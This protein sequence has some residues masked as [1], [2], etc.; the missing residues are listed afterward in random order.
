MKALTDTQVESFVTHQL[1]VSPA[2]DS[3]QECLPSGSS[4]VEYCFAQLTRSAFR[5]T[6]IDDASANDVKRK[7]DS[8][9]GSHKPI[10]LAIPF[11][12]YKNYR[13]ASFPGP[14]WAEVF[15]MNYLAR[16]VMPLARC[17]KPGVILQYT[18]ISGVM[19]LVSN[20]PVSPPIT[21]MEQ[22]RSL[23]SIFAAH[24]PTNLRLTTVDIG[25]HYSK[26]ALIEELQH[27]YEDNLARWVDKFSP[28]EREKRIA[29]AGRNLMRVGAIDLSYLSEVEWST[30]CVDSAM[31]CEALDSL[32]LRRRFNK[33]SDNIQLVFVRG[34]NLSIHI[35]SCDTSA[36]HFWS[37]CGVLEPNDTG[38]KQRIMSGEKLARHR[39]EGLV[40]D[41]TV[42]TIFSDISSTFS[43]IP[44][45]T[46]SGNSESPT[47]A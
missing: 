32:T 10:T 3:Y 16:Y 39:Q 43:R 13:A 36:H 15:N 46:S 18:Y 45:L 14:D 2:L 29:S 1:D 24:L 11:G 12:G 44:V 40:R 35:G 28:E 41:V 31:W 42:N 21:Y 34:P 5:R 47:P 37:G 30:R 17:Y 6:R 8:A 38:F 25:T 23:L 9:I 26:A 19:D 4:V 7:L 22:F 27:N 33:Y 20:I